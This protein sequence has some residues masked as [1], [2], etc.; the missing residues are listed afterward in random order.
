MK[1]AEYLA[2]HKRLLKVLKAAGKEAE[3]QQKELK[4]RGL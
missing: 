2:E 4:E 3:L 1:K